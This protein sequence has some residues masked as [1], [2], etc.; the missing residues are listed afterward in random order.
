MYEWYFVWCVGRANEVVG[1]LGQLSS[2]GLSLGT[3]KG[4]LRWL[5]NG[6]LGGFFFLFVVVVGSLGMFWGLGLGAE[7]RRRGPFRRRTGKWKKPD[8]G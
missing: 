3:R 5:R 7:R 2:D 8:Y 4:A 6:F 1:G